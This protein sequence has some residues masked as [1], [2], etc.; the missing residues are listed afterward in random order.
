MKQEAAEQNSL[1]V[2]AWNSFGRLFGSHN[3]GRDPD[4]PFQES[5]DE[6]TAPDLISLRKTAAEFCFQAAIAVPHQ[7][8]K[9]V[10]NDTRFSLDECS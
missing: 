8:S 7:N 3:R 5:L 6:C 10:K 9:R 1:A 2:L 4:T